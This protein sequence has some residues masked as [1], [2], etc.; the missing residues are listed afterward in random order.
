MQAQRTTVAAAVALIIGGGAALA[1]PMSASA[2]PSPTVHASGVVI[3]EV[4]SDGDTTD[5]IE[6][7]NTGDA[8]VDLSGW[9]VKDN[10]DTRDFRFAAGTS[11]QPGAYLVVDDTQFG[12]GL[13]NLMQPLTL[14][15]QNS[16]PPQ[17]MGVSTSSATFFRQIGG[18][19]GVAAFLSLLFSRVT[20]TIRDALIQAAATPEFRTAV[21]EA[22]QSSDPT[23]AGL[24]RGLASGDGSAAGGV[25]ED[26]SFIQ[27][28]PTA[29]GD[30]FR[31]GFSDAMDQVFVAAG[32]LLAVGFVIN[33]FH[34]EI[35]LRTQGGLAAQRAELAEP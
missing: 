27:K 2:A 21:G 35:P 26:T 17:D 19:I 4:E 29:L 20:D 13:G 22:A 7:V 5:W 8:P 15:I 32:V 10:D 12:F 14:A 16:L 23:V 9:A 24:A 1:A 33:L 3:N 25:L 30:P 18:T 31:I 11:I 28:L 34:K 6:L